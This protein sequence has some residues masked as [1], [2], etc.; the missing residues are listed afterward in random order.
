M[1][2]IGTVS[3]RAD[4]GLVGDEDDL[5]AYWPMNEAAGSPTAPD[6]AAGSYPGT[7]TNGAYFIASPFAVTP[8][9]GG[10][11]G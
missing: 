3:C 6:E 9:V 7:M 11:I 1:Q 2:P 8:S 5:L 10:D 4:Y